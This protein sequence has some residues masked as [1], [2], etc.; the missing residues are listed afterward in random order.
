M[1]ALLLSLVALTSIA[2]ADDATQRKKARA[3]RAYTLTEELSLDE[4]T[5]AKLFPML[6]RYDGEADKIETRRAEIR[7][8]LAATTPRTATGEINALV[9]ESIANQKW[10]RD[11][12]DR[13]LADLRKILTALQVAR[14]VTIDLDARGIE[15]V[16]DDDDAPMPSKPSKQSSCNPFNQRIPC[17]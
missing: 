14:V 1:R 5:A 10:Q 9:D 15:L 7:R 11:L 13:R 3:M 2:H 16:E 6:A 8:K 17:R 12:E 4:Q